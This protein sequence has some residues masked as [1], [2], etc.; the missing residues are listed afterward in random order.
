MFVFDKSY[1]IFSVIQFFN[2]I[3]FYLPIFILCPQW[4]IYLPQILPFNFQSHSSLVPVRVLVSVTYATTKR[5]I[6]WY[7]C[8]YLLQNYYLFLSVSPLKLLR[9][10]YKCIVHISTPHYIN[11]NMV[12]LWIPFVKFYPNIVIVKINTTLKGCATWSLILKK[13]CRLGYWKQ[14]PEANIST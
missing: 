12:S 2:A 11:L 5:I 6:L 13:E 8:S 7:I 14:D 1:N 4:T 10:S 9:Y 3:L